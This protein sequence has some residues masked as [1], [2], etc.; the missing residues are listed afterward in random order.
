MKKR[1]INQPRKFKKKLKF[2]SAFPPASPPS[3]THA[4]PAPA[5]A[6]PQPEVLTRT[7]STGTEVDIDPD[8]NTSPPTISNLTSG[9]SERTQY[10]AVGGS[11]GSQIR[12]TGADAD[13]EARII[14][15][16]ETEV[17]VD[18]VRDLVQE[19]SNSVLNSVR[20][21]EPAFDAEDDGTLTKVNNTVASAT[22]EHITESGRRLIHNCIAIYAE[23]SN[24]VNVSD[25][26][27]SPNPNA[28]FVYD[29][30]PPSDATQVLTDDQKLLLVNSI[31]TT[32]N[33]NF[34]AEK[35]KPYTAVR[36]EGQSVEVL[37]GRPGEGKDWF[38]V[39][40]KTRSFKQQIIKYIGG[41]TDAV[42][43]EG[44][45]KIK[46]VRLRIIAFKRCFINELSL[47]RAKLLGQDTSLREAV[48]LSRKLFCSTNVRADIERIK[49]FVSSFETLYREE[50]QK[51]GFSQ[52]NP[53][54]I[55]AIVHVS[56]RNREISNPA[57][58]RQWFSRVP[59]NDI[60]KYIYIKKIISQAEFL[61]NLSYQLAILDFETAIK[62][63]AKELA[64]E[65][66]LST[67]PDPIQRERFNFMTFC[68]E[69][70]ALRNQGLDE[71]NITAA[72]PGTLYN[73]YNVCC[74]VMSSQLAR[75]ALNVD[76]GRSY[77]AMM[78]SL[79][80]AYNS[81][82]SE[83]GPGPAEDGERLMY[84]EYNSP[85][86]QT[87]PAFVE[88]NLNHPIIQNSNLV[89]Y[90]MIRDALK[91]LTPTNQEEKDLIPMKLLGE[92]L[93]PLDPR[94]G[95]IPISYGII[96]RYLQF[97]LDE[98]DRQYYLGR[99]IKQIGSFKV[100]DPGILA[101]HIKGLIT[102]IDELAGSLL[103]ANNYFS[104]ARVFWLRSFS[105]LHQLLQLSGEGLA[106]GA[107]FLNSIK[108]LPLIINLL[109]TTA[110]GGGLIYLKSWALLKGTITLICSKVAIP[111]FATLTTN[112]AMALLMLCYFSAAH[113]RNINSQGSIGNF[114]GGQPPGGRA[115]AAA[116]VVGDVL[117]QN[118][119]DVIGK[120]L[121]SSEF[122][123]IRITT[124][125]N[126]ND[127]YATLYRGVGI[128]L[129]SDAEVPHQELDINI[130]L[131]SKLARNPS[132]I[133]K[134]A[135]EFFN[136]NPKVRH[137]NL[138]TPTN[139]FAH[140]IETLEPL[141]V[142]Y[143]DPDG[144]VDIDDNT[145]S[146]YNELIA[147]DNIFSMV[148]NNEGA[149]MSSFIETP[150]RN[151]LT[152]FGPVVDMAGS[153]T[154]SL[155]TTLCSISTLFTPVKRTTPEEQTGPEI[156]AGVGTVVFGKV[157]KLLKPYRDFV[158]MPKDGSRI[159]TPI[160]KTKFG[161]KRIRDNSTGMYV[162]AN[163]KKWYIY[164]WGEKIPG[165]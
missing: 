158:K 91:I 121:R 93:R 147:Y 92:F 128:K 151:M 144:M 81:L 100:D 133:Y 163:G 59:E 84:V 44:D 73:L 27:D 18:A 153:H 26:S 106:L 8:P 79:I 138:P 56:A 61:I 85:N 53:S 50:A 66:L 67:S 164:K 15:A 14:R 108:N 39:Y 143:Y 2:G 7:T 29:V 101:D 127:I 32:F 68:I 104:S 140:V 105:S 137:R 119:L 148:P 9:S 132:V 16:V 65:A 3:S 109:Y 159:K 96:Y 76:T 87:T 135:A 62:P 125:D 165:Y 155:F 86:K 40:K 54:I 124:Y 112:P 78:E 117:K 141:E 99:L 160:L 122:P 35:R 129:N 42:M 23:L 10:V 97:A 161:N 75:Y 74:F 82:I 90:Q 45:W 31:L 111:T 25:T 156:P 69:V 52:E 113:Q 20:V 60:C 110:Q 77:Y 123:F 37:D 126:I 22:S 6:S 49:A 94:V 103:T 107:F 80:T 41:F 58:I 48:R 19:A 13:T 57:D 46:D 28:P 136:N 131:L 139:G 21:D 98:D 1:N 71:G 154:V 36:T 116:H 118:I 5:A 17:P 34:T 64:A 149:A 72:T 47:M 115:A 120:H 134:A 162:K 88:I 142:E 146:Y 152:V 157:R 55:E 38:R 114:N 11:Q 43:R 89:P 70:F 4:S 130:A 24:N 145:K 12:L 83:V 33:P 51:L 30:T 102:K 95:G 63:K 150:I